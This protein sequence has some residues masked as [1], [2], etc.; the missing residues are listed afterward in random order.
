MK[1]E[2]NEPVFHAETVP[3]GTAPRESVY[4]PHPNDS[5]SQ[6]LNPNVERG[7][8]KESVKTTAGQS[9]TGSTSQTVNTGIGKPTQGQTSTEIRHDGEHGRKNPGVS[10]EGVGASKPDRFERD[11]PSQ[12]GY[13]RD[14]AQSGNRGD[15]GAFAAEERNPEPPGTLASEWKY[16]PGTKR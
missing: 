12:R 6:A 9:L 14:D 13:E 4:V 2:D 10:L 11:M 1:P 7:H 16:E 3:P 8:G 15:K 5:G